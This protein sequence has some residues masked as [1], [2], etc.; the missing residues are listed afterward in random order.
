MNDLKIKVE[1]DIIRNINCV[2]DE[3]FESSYAE[4]EEEEE[5]NDNHHD[6]YGVDPGGG[7]GGGDEADEEEEEEM[8][9]NHINGKSEDEDQEI[10]DNLHDNDGD[11]ESAVDVDQNNNNDDDDD[12]DHNDINNR[13][14][15]QQMNLVKPC[16]TTSAVKFE[17]NSPSTC[18]STVSDQ[19]NVRRRYAKPN[20][21]AISTLQPATSSASAFGDL[22]VETK[23]KSLPL[24][25]PLSVSS[26]SS[27]IN[28]KD[29][30]SSNGGLMSKK[31]TT[32][33]LNQLGG[34][35]IN[36]RPLPAETRERIVQLAN[37]GVRPC[38]ISRKLQVSHGCVSKILKR[39]RLFQTTSPGLIGGSKPKVATPNVVKKIREYKRL[40]PQIFAWEIRKKLA[41]YS[42]FLSN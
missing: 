1:T 27:S 30:S 40:N 22:S 36:G 4:E 34:E 39:Y 9:R 42:L 24:V 19:K 33:S 38:E 14:Q 20:A 31:P 32:A 21:A 8:N 26:T 29:I 6:R 7:G 15:Q 13:Q 17:D 28:S 16:E 18:S 25:T 12:E 41:F 5:E 11:N 3:E 35:F 37:Q 10:E 23:F 2:K